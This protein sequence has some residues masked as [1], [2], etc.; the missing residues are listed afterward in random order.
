V[1]FFLSYYD[2]K[3]DLCLNFTPNELKSYPNHT[4][5][6][7][8]DIKTK[9]SDIMS[10]LS[11][12]IETNVTIDFDYNIWNN[13]P[14]EKLIEIFLYPNITHL[15]NFILVEVNA[16]S[17]VN[18]K[19]ENAVIYVIDWTSNLS[20][21]IESMRDT[22]VNYFSTNHSNFNINVSTIW[23]GF[24]NSPQILIVEHYLFKSAFWEMELSRHVTIAPHDW[25]TVYLRPRFSLIPNWSGTINSWSSGNHTINEI[26]PP[27]EIFR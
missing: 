27:E 6:L 13:T 22:F 20:P 7:L 23:N 4:A 15:D 8:L 17:G 9:N 5:W 18:S 19:T 12:T 1:I 3:Q 21:L 11:F 14:A 26:D 16:V 25:V 2:Q 10:N 24:G